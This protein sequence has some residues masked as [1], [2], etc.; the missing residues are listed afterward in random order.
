MMDGKHNPL[1]NITA[2]VRG[3]IHEHSISKLA[4]LKISKQAI[5]ILMKNIH[6]N[7]IK[8]LTYLILN[9]MEIGKQ[10]NTCPPS[11]RE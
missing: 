4:N 1:I 5:N 3:A 2:S 6:Q 11:L 9:K 10:T 7:A 8:Y